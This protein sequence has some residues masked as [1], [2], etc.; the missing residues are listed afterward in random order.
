MIQLSRAPGAQACPELAAVR[1]A[2]LGRVREALR[3][4]KALD[5]KLLGLE[6]KVARRALADAQRY[7]CCY[8]E[9]R[10]QDDR[11][12]HVEHFRPKAEVTRS[13]TSPPEPGYWW[14][15]WTWENLLFSCVRCNH[16]KGSAFPLLQGSSALEAEQAPPGAERPELIDPALEDPREHIQF[17]PFGEHWLPRPRTP[18]GAAMLRA[19]GL[20][21][22]PTDEGHR[23][24][25][26]AGVG[27]PRHAAAA[28]DRGGAA[29][30]REQRRR[31]RARR[32][33]EHPR[34]SRCL[35]ALR[36]PRAR[37]ARPPRARARAAPLG[38]RAHRPLP[39]SLITATATERRRSSRRRGG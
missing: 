8:C 39:V 26:A 9:E 6:Y 7:K 5:Q 22:E 18:R 17:R 27:R 2:E 28:G 1:E 36:R 37:R 30:D 32:L 15:T 20:G 23:V 21:L 24:G 13:A 33:G 16:T 34:V 11:W 4:G 35:T 19:V 12:Q 31:A 3:E 38:P 29:R 14:L 25:L 10:Q